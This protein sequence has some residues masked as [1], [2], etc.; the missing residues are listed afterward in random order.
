MFSQKVGI[1]VP[2]T[3]CHS[4]RDRLK[5]DIVVFYMDRVERSLD[6]K[7][8]GIKRTNTLLLLLKLKW[9]EILKNFIQYVCIKLSVS[10]RSIVKRGFP[11][12]NPSNDENV[13]V[14]TI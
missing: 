14:K 11:D 7:G 6:P 1:S 2:V 3:G 10:L 5:C 8:L 4:P 9:V 12:L 13:R